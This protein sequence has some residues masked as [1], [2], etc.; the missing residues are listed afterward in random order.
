MPTGPTAVRIAPFAAYILFL[1][2]DAPLSAWLS[3]LGLD[4]R[5][6]YACRV[7][8]AAALL[9]WFWREYAELARPAR[10]PLRAWVA[11]LLAGGAVFALWILPYPVWATLGSES[12]GFAP[13]RADGS[14]DPLLAA[15]RLSGAALVVPLME[16]LF[17][18]SWLMRWMDNPDFHLV[19]PARVGLRALFA[20]AALFAVEH[21]LW[22][23]GLLAGLTYGGLY[24]ISRNLWVPVLAHAVTNGALGFWVLHRGAWHYW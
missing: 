19:D 11:A 20:A 9:V 23:A 22:L 17:W 8:T 21:D 14:V 16:E 5:W 24:M 6:L 18:R 2:L 15:V 4:A 3:G 7:G 13:T 12:A 1:A 10:V